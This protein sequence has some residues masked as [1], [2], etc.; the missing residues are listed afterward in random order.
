M[1]TFMGLAGY[2]LLLVGAFFI[3]TPIIAVL[4]IPIFLA[5]IIILMKFYNKILKKHNRLGMLGILIIC[6]TLGY[7]CVEF[8]QFLVLL[9]RDNF[10]GINNTGWAKIG[11]VAVLVLLSVFFVYRSLGKENIHFK[12]GSMLGWWLSAILLIPFVLLLYWIAYKTG[13]WMGG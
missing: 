8:N 3:D 2:S 9:S 5:G 4:A 10:S 11:I 7:V 6:L 12:Q 13:N 1:R